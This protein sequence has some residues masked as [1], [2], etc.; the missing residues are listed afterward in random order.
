MLLA[1]TFPTLSHYPINR[2]YKFIV[3]SYLSKDC[4]LCKKVKN[5]HFS[6]FQKE[7]KIKTILWFKQISAIK[8]RMEKEAPVNVFSAHHKHKNND[9]FHLY[10]CFAWYNAVNTLRNFLK[11]TI[12]FFN[13][14]I[15]IGIKKNLWCKRANYHLF[16]S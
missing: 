7:K 8:I 15:Y 14:W 9:F 11:H 2:C 6:I 16:K 3:S 1:Y 5:L 10:K 13:V 12:L 4:K